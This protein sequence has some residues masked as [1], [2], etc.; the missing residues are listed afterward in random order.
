MPL[1]FFHLAGPDEN[2]PDSEG[3]EF[4]SVEDA[5]LD[6]HRAVLDI[7]FDMLR[8]QRDP[9]R[10]RFDVRDSSGRLLFELPFS[11]VLRPSPVAR[12]GR[13]ATVLAGIEERLRHSSTL[14]TDLAA[15]IAEAG[16]RVRQMQAT[17]QGGN[18]GLPS[19][20]AEEL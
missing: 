15:K 19:Q 1:F 3:V 12:G 20:L 16:M 11:E 14:Q 18:S 2:S 5:F 8:R 4:A 7:S 6:V 17:L 9:H 13:Q 10:Y